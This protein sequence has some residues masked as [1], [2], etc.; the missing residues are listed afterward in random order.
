MTLLKSIFGAAALAT[1]AVTLGHA[2]EASAEMELWIRNDTD[3]PPKSGCGDRTHCTKGGQE[4]C[5]ATSCKA[6]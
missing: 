1:L 2:P 5:T 6:C 3:C 4:Q